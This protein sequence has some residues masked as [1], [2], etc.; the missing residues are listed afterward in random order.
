MYD[1]ESAKE[2]SDTVARPAVTDP[3][4]R[5]FSRHAIAG[6]A[7]LLSLGNRAAW[8]GATGNAGCMSVMTLNSFNPE[9]GMFVSAP[10]GRQEHDEDLARAI[11]QIGNP[12]GL[13]NPSSYTGVSSDGKWRVCEEPGTLDRV[14]L[15]RVNGGQC[16]R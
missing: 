6:S 4:R 14:C 3:S 11:H 9:T 5:K 2:R 7:V 13:R 10:A 1:D 8:G 12:N 16:P 15:I